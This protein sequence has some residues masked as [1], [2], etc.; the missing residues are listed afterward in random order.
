MNSVVTFAAKADPQ[1]TPLCSSY[2]DRDTALANNLT[3]ITEDGK[4]I[5][6]GDDTTW[7]DSGV[8]R[9]RCVQATLYS[10][11]RC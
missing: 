10:V 2:T 9:N 4:V 8:Y 6:K 5:M 11:H 3:F 7:L 1:V